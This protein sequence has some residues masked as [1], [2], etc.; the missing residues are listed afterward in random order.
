MIGLRFRPVT[1]ADAD[2]LL[3]WRNDPETRE[4]SRNT[5]IVERDGH[6]AWLKASL[7]NPTRKLSIA[8]IDGRP[9]GTIRTDT[10]GGVCELSWTVAPQARGKGI[11]KAMVKAIADEI[12]IPVRSEIRANN[13]ASKRIA[14]LE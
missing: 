3:A 2:L 10:S 9:V 1:M 8:E 4:Q 6:I 14:E 11:G 5:S 7:S 12:D 13:E